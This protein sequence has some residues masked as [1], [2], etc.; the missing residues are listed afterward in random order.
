MDGK[1]APCKDCKMRYVGCHSE[2]LKYINWKQRREIENKK[3]R[4]ESDVNQT[5]NRMSYHRV[6][7][8]NYK[9]YKNGHKQSNR[10]HNGT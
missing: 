6:N 9:F 3:R 1:I 10:R 2:C 8:M 4:A 7:N 5:L